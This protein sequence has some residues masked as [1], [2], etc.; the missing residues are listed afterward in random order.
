MSDTLQYSSSL[1]VKLDGVSETLT[2]GQSGQSRNLATLSEGT[3]GMNTLSTS[4]TALNFGAVDDTERSWVCLQNLSNTTGEDITIGKEALPQVG[5]GSSFTLDGTPT[6]AGASVPN[7]LTGSGYYRKIISD[8]VS[9]G[10][11]WKTGDVAVYLGSSGVWGRIPITE[12]SIIRA[13]DNLAFPPVQDGKA[14]YAKAATGTPR[15]ANI[16]AGALG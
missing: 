8:G 15:L 6:Q 13:N 5:S 7:T 14:L 4:W 11:T 1:T 2:L 9:Q 12:F 10:I 3:A 16:A